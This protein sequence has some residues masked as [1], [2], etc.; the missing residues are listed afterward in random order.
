MHIKI[1]F[2]VKIPV[3]KHRYSH[4]KY[5]GGIYEKEF[6]FGRYVDGN[7]YCFVYLYYGFG[8]GKQG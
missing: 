1:N 7:Y 3:T 6:F 8:N 5:T 2:R 4:L